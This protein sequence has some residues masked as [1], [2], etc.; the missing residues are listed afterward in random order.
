MPSLPQLTLPAQ[1]PGPGSLEN[2]GTRAFAFLQW[3][4]A[5]H[6]PELNA[7]VTALNALTAGDFGAASA[8]ALT[9]LSSDFEGHAA[10]SNPHSGS[11]S[12]EELEA[13][14]VE[15]S[16][17][18][19]G[20]TAESEARQA[21]EAAANPHSGSAST[22]AL[23]SVSEVV[24]DIDA[25][26]AAEVTARQVFQDAVDQTLLDQQAALDDAVDALETA[27]NLRALAAR[28]ISTTFPVQGGGNLE[29]DRTLTLALAV[30]SELLGYGVTLSGKVVTDQILKAATKLL[31]ASNTTIYVATTGSDAT[32]TG[33]AGAPFA[34]ISKALSSI[35]GMLIASGVVV[36]IQCAD[37]AY[38]VGGTITIDHPDAD[39]IRI[40]GNV[41]AETAISVASIDAANKKFV[42]TGNYTATAGLSSGDKFTVTGSST[43]ALNRSY[44]ISGAP[45]YTGGNTEITV[46]ESIASSTVGG[47][48]ITAKP[49][50]KCVL[51]TSGNIVTFKIAKNLAQLAGFR[52]NGPGIASGQAIQPCVGAQT[53]IYRMIVSGYGFGLSSLTSAFTD[54]QDTLF[55]G[56]GYGI[57]TQGF[58]K[59]SCN[60]GTKVV[61]DA[62]NYGVTAVSGG[63]NI[64]PTSVM[65]MANAAVADYSPA[66]TGT[67]NQTLSGAMNIPS[68]TV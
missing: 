7:W 62:C 29:A 18:D 65:T 58:A 66:A 32:G 40:L 19:A 67:T 41:S 45:V 26:L 5:T 28:A 12:T 15:V 24:A 49:C 34:S 21:H 53:L 57:F 13:V 50:N 36:T 23:A 35:A 46:S 4:Y 44:T 20:L 25:D 61:C 27:V 8:T 3:W 9:A 52:L 55:Y 37:G 38:A 48:V 17:L 39:K 60:T 42:V 54:L 63:K 51:N 59:V 31:I 16:S 14:S 10:A 68:A 33:L 22:G 56:C 2:F 43:A 1:P 47:A 6:G 30:V 11:A 64:V